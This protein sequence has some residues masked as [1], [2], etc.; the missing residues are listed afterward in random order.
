MEALIKHLISLQGC[1][2][3]AN[4][5]KKKM[6][7]GPARLKALEQEVAQVE[8]QLNEELGKVDS[9]KREK[10]TLEQEIEDLENQT[11]K[12]NVKLAGIKSNKEYGAAL[13]EIEDLGRKKATCEERVIEIM[14]EL[15]ALKDTCD[16]IN[17]KK[18]AATKKLGQDQK[19]IQNELKTLDRKFKN[20]EKERVRIR[21]EI[22]KD[23]LKKYDFICDHKEGTGISAVINSV[24][25]TCHM[26]IPPQKFNELMRG[27]ALMNCP[28]CSRLIYWGDDEKF[29]KEEE[30]E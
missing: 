6:T 24:C 3:Q 12:S 19:D 28:H 16:S 11:E 4:E 23:I 20:H 29:K 1:D 5:I 30:L 9:V 10:R 27:D 14:E 21:K 2:D 25:Q 26:G 17:T 8:K 22:D 13:K 18:E 7:V 15:E